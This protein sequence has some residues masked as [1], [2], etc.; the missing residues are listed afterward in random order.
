M[1]GKW[2]EPDKFQPLD[3]YKEHHIEVL[4]AQLAP[5][6]KDLPILVSQ[7]LSL[8]KGTLYAIDRQGKST[9][10]SHHLFCPATGRSFDELDPRLFHLIALT[11]GVPTAKDTEP[12]SQNL[13]NPIPRMKPNENSSWNLRVKRFLMVSFFPA[14]PAKG[15]A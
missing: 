8:G 3:R 9:I 13:P 1:D 12:C 11:D 6:Q 7:A 10:H 15:L 4:V 14:H 5:K 2:V